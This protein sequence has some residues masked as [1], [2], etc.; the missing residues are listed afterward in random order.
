MMEKTYSVCDNCGQI[1]RVDL[2]SS[3]A[4]ICGACKAEL[5]VHG[6]LVDGHDNSFEKLVAK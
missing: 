5:P 1:N 3:K 6:A 2:S 4:A